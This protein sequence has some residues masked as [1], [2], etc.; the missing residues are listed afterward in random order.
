MLALLFMQYPEAT[1]PQVTGQC[2]NSV[3]LVDATPFEARIGRE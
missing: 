3:T 1:V 2:I